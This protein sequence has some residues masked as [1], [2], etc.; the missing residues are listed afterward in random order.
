MVSAFERGLSGSNAFEIIQWHFLWKDALIMPDGII[1]CTKQGYILIHGRFRWSSN[2]DIVFPRDCTLWHFPL[3]ANFNLFMLNNKINFILNTCYLLPHNLRVS[4]FA[5]D[6]QI[7]EYIYI[8]ELI[9][10]IPSN[11]NTFKVREKP[12]QRTKALCDMWCPQCCFIFW[13]KMMW[14]MSSTDKSK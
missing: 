2:A 11:L 12:I 4:R 13:C 10:G 5:Q 1:Q 7:S 6:I 14:R 8:V 9:L 3:R